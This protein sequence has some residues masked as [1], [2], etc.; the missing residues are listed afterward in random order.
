MIR[1]ILCGCNGRMGHVVRG[2]VDENEDMQVVA[3]VDITPGDGSFPVFANAG[4][5]DILRML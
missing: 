4:E 3:G 1:I 2:I 5:C